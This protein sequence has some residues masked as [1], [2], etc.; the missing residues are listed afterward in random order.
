MFAWIWDWISETLNSLGL[1]QKT[2]KLLFLGLDNA[3]KT[4][5]LHML[6]SDCLGQHAPTL[7]A[8][9]EELRLGGMR[10]RTFDLG[11]HKQARRVWRD[12]FPTVDAVVYL[13]DCAD[14][15]RLWEAKVE[16]DS[17]LADEQIS[18]CPILVL[19]NKIDK[20][21]AVNELELLNFFEISGKTTGKEK[22]L[23]SETH[24]R[25]LEL[26]MCSIL[27]RQGYGDAFRW[28]AKYLK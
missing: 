8:T 21:A 13:V 18:Q 4:T 11:G 6:K 22:I 1:T 7:H 9:S 19:G 12:Y 10:L 23:G 14:R 28:L 24:S 15:E 26:F 2:G 17:L 27:R 20:P 5:L 25:P 16:F 3:G